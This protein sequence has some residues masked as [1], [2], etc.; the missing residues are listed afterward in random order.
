MGGQWVADLSGALQSKR[1]E[2]FARVCNTRQPNAIASDHSKDRADQIALAQSGQVCSSRG[3]RRFQFAPGPPVLCWSSAGRFQSGDAN[4]RS[5][6]RPSYVIVRRSVDTLHF[7]SNWPDWPARQLCQP[8]RVLLG[9]NALRP[10]DSRS[11]IGGY[12]N[13]TAG[14]APTPSLGSMTGWAPSGRMRRR[15]LLLYLHQHAFW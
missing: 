9:E 4:V 8:I 7:E 11:R 15:R 10:T 3:D 5:R 12:H 13:C 6:S 14:S 1:Q 2:K